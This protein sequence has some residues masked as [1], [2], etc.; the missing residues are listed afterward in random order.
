LLERSLIRL[1]LRSSGYLTR[2]KEI[3][4]AFTTPTIMRIYSSINALYADDDE[5]DT[6][7]LAESLD[8]PDVEALADIMENIALAGNEESVFNECVKNVKLSDLSEREEEIIQ[9]LTLANE[10]ENK[11]RIDQLSHEL[12]LIQRQI[13]EVKGW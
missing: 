2:I 5:I 10:D 11:D 3:E 9:M 6:R 13:K 8:E 4:R 7:K 12:L 1:A